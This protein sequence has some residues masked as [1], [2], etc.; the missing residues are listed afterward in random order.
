[1]KHG[2]ALRRANDKSPRRASAFPSIL[3]NA[4]SVGSTML[5]GRPPSSFTRSAPA[6]S[7]PAPAEARGGRP[8][9]EI[10]PMDRA[11]AWLEIDPE[12][13]PPRIENPATRYGVWWHDFAQKI[14]WHSHPGA[15][16]AAFDE[17]VSN[18][19]DPARSR[20]EWEL[21]SN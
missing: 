16:Q 2:N 1:M 17:S 14:P 12:L 6:N 8:E 4:N 15:W 11:D 19:P 18:S 13:R 21:V 5:A 20:R 3:G 10:E 9:K 7:L